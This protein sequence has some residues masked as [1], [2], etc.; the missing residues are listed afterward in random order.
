MTPE[1]EF[2]R[3]RWRCRR[4]M[5]ELDALLMA[6]ADACYRDAGPAGQAAFRGLLSLP[7][8]EIVALLNGSQRSEDA[9]I[10]RLV[11]QL[12]ALRVPGGS[13]HPA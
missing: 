4:G 2:N 13:Q 10:T 7:D 1:Q 9:G 12:L 8:P 5:R 11:E 3:L 6:Y